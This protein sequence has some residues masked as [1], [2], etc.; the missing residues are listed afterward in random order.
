MEQRRLAK[1]SS[2]FQLYVSWGQASRTSAK[3]NPFLTSFPG[4][5]NSPALTIAPSS[6]LTSLHSRQD[7]FGASIH[8]RNHV[9]QIMVCHIA[10][11]VLLQA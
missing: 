1:W 9:C 2:L 7:E 5:E 6:V 8:A 10:R 3:R 4:A 11:T